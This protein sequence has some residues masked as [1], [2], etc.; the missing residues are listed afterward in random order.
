[1]TLYLE[2]KLSNMQEIDIL[3]L[4]QNTM[5]RLQDEKKIDNLQREQTISSLGINSLLIMEAIGDIQDELDI[6]LPE[7]KLSQIKTV[8]ELESL[9][10]EYLN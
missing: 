5:N 1:M 7:Q 3:Q 6:T 8:G 2:K 4:L 10:M 9:I